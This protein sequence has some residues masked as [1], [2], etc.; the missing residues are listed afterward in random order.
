MT[1]VH[2]V[3]GGAALD[4]ARPVSFTFDGVAYG[5]YEGDTLASALLANG[6][7][8][9]GRSYKYHRPRGILS[10]GSEEPNALV[11]V[12]N[13]PGRFTPNLR[14]TQVELF[15]GLVATS[16]NRWPSL[17]FD[18]GAI[19]DIAS[20]LFAAGFYYKTFMGPDVFGK[21]W[22]WTRIYE[23]AIRLAAGL[24]AAPREPDPDRYARYFDHCDVMIVGAGPAGLAAALAAGASGARVVICDENPAPG[25][26]LLTETQARI[27]D[28]SAA[29]WLAGALAALRDQPNVRLMPRT[30]AFGYYAQNFIALSERLAEP[31]LAADADL[32]RER[33]W[34]M[35]AREVVLATGAIER[36]LVFAD[37]DRPGMMLADAARRY[38]NQ[39][40]VR[41]G[42][43]I[44]VVTAHDTAYRAALDLKQAGAHVELIADLRHEA[45]GP[46]ME[47]ARAAGIRVV[48]KAAMHEVRGGHR[49]EAVR[50]SGHPG[51]M[52]TLACD[53][54]LM[55]GGWTPSV[56][57]FSQS[58]GKLVFDDALQ[59]FRPG[60]SA[61]RERSAGACNASFDLAE[62]LAEGDAA[63]RAASSAA[64]FAAPD[65]RA[66]PV[67][68]VLRSGGGTLGAPLHVL[69]ARHA[70]AFV[71]FQNDVC[72]KDVELAVQEGMRS[73][74]H[75]KRY[76]TT[77]MATD[78]GKLSNMNALAIAAA[79]QEKPIP[80]VGLTTFRPPYTPVTF[81]AFA[82]PARGDLFD[83]IRRTPIHDW[84]A[85]RG[86]A[87][88]DVGL[89]KRAW[90]FPKPGESMHEAVAREC[91]TTRNAVGL[92]DA[93]TLG[94]IEV[95]GPDAAAF[96]ERMY[97]NAFRKLE[98]GRCRYGL[99]LS[100][101]GFLMDDGVIARVAPD[102]F[103]VTTTTGGAPRV[104]AHMEDYLQTEFTD[105]QVWLT[106][107]TEQ[108]AVIAV[109]G[110]KARETIA[111]LIEGVD[112]ANEAFP[113]LSLR[114]ARVHGLAIR[115][116]RVSFTGELGYEINAPSA[117]GRAVWE[118]VW[119]EA[120]KH[121]GCAY[122]T[123]AM[124]VMRAEK[125]YVIV[126]QETDG[127]VTLADL[128]LEWAIGKTKKDFVGKRSLTRPDMLLENRKQLVGL[129]TEDP[130]VVLEE[131][132]QVT[133]SAAPPVGAPALGHVTSSYRSETLGRSIALAMV[134]AGRSRIGGKLI[135]PMPKDAVPVTVSA[136]IFYDKPGARLH[137]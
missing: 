19:N 57:L 33:L 74:E 54:L 106:S 58:R 137:V 29:D 61:Q 6:V 32:P 110:P 108:W 87:F 116:M 60:V 127:T 36:P 122:G 69:G 81:G 42:E 102:R 34:Q 135:V 133:D 16:Q 21:N 28:R 24:G 88:E 84:A 31:D 50:L 52:R 75:I 8:L 134:A 85:E 45:S 25:G 59:V 89:W 111:P 56:H 11:G 100:E 101:A 120:E 15:D 117:Y 114:D 77:G 68:G 92:F 99:M 96:L 22:A 97:A 53:A 124:H 51:G 43:R 49:V 14:A 113:H 10:A 83:P 125:G 79:I 66:Y 123:E 46:W 136:P 47:A 4:R 27:D 13:G 35:R 126:G 91:R 130:N 98:V 82:G 107:T 129:L 9:V 131:G 71:D 2:R 93:T 94:K 103:H 44:V 78:Q 63:G 55:S 73:I 105:L 40:A 76:T 62:A 30:Q 3:P 70:K 1:Q 17:K 132:A 23:P 112:L 7:R 39:Y 12:S 95:V 37:N 64:G 80:E 26:S 128:G 20:P 121:G 109:Q 67:E 86:A 115:L 41:V 18:I 5:G 104:L 118:A 38:L 119:A 65:K 90:Y 48:I 72:V